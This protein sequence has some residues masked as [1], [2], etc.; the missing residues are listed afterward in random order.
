[1]TSSRTIH[2][3]MHMT[4]LS[5]WPTWQTL[6]E[7]LFNVK[8]QYW[9]QMSAKDAQIEQLEGTAQTEGQRTQSHEHES[10]GRGAQIE[11]RGEDA[12]FGV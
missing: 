3:H 11:V 1:M 8:L 2:L 10:G 9:E 5:P 7:E 6:N 4:A 12:A